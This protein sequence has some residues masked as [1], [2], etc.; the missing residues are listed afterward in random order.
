MPRVYNGICK[1]TQN[2]K[3]GGPKEGKSKTPPPPA[4]GEGKDEKKEGEGE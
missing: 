4:E 1:P 3:R 2:K